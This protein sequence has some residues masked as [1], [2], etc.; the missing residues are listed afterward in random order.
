MEEIKSN[1]RSL[2]KQ[3]EEEQKKRGVDG[4]KTNKELQLIE[5]KQI[6]VKKAITVYSGIN[7]DYLTAKINT[8]Y[9]GK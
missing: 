1:I 2:N 4:T 8:S 6:L 5:K 7:G 3:I 9:K